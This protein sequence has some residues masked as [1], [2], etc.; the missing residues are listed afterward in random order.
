MTLRFPN[1][2]AF[3]LVVISGLIGVL[4]FAALMGVS[5][6]Q[7]RNQRID[8]A[9]IETENISLVLEAHALATVQKIDLILKDVQGH[10]RP[11][12]MCI[13]Q[14]DNFDGTA[15]HTLLKEKA[16]GIHKT[17]VIDMAGIYI[18]NVNGDCIHSSL[19]APSTFNIADR[20]YFQ[21]HRDNLA[22]GLLISAPQISRSFGTW[23][24]SFT[25][26]INFPNG[27]F[28]GVINVSVELSSFEKFYA[29]LNLGE[30]G[31]ILLRD[32]KMRLLARHP[33]LGA[34]IGEVMLNHPVLSFLE[35]GID[36][37]TYIAISP[38]DG[39]KRLYSFRRVGEYPLYVLA[40]I[41]EQDYLAD[42][43]RHL[44]WN[45][46]AAL[47]ILSAAL[48]LAMVARYG[49]LKWQTN[50][51]KYRYLVENAP[52]GVFQCD[53]HGK[54]IF[55]NLA[56]AKQFNCDSVESFQKTYNSPE[57]R[58]TTPAKL[59]A[60]KDAL[61]NQREISEFES[62][63]VLANG[64]TKWFSISAYLDEQTGQ[65]N[66]FTL[67]I[68]ERK[69]VEEQL[70]TSEERLRLTLEAAQIGVFDWDVKK[71]HFEVSPI[72][73]SMLGYPVKSGQGD[74]NEWLERLHPDDR[75]S[76]AEKIGAVLA[77]QE[78]AY[79]YEARMRHADGTYR[80]LAVKAFCV[81][82][83]EDGTVTRVL[84]IRVDITERKRSQE[85]LEHYKDHLERLV[86]E[87]T[88]ELETARKQADDANQ[89]KSDFLANMSHEIRTPMNAIIGLSQLALDTSL[90]EKQHD[91]LSKILNSSRALL[92]ILND[93]LDYSKIEAGR[94]E[95]EA[96]EFSLEEML[97]ATADLF[98][99]RADEKGLELF[100]DMAPDVPD[101]LLGD[102]LRLSQIIN[103]LVG[104][105]IKF[106]LQGEV[107]L[108]I[109][110]LERTND[111]I[112]LRFAVRDT[113]IGITT[114]QASR[115]FQPFVQ[116][117][118]S[119]TR[120]FG[121]T[122]LGLTICKRLVDMMGGEI[123]LSSGPDC[124]S[125]F[126]FTMRLGLPPKPSS[127]KFAKGRGLQN[128]RTMRTLVVDDQET[129][130]TIL[131]TILESWHF[132]VVTALS[133]AEG[134][135]LFAESENL[136][137]PFELLLLD[138]RMPNMSGLELAKTLAKEKHSCR[139]PVSIMVTAFGREELAKEANGVKLDA[140]IIKPVTPSNLFDT[141]IRLQ[142][143][144]IV[145]PIL[146][147]EAF[148]ASRETLKA[149]RGAHILLV[150]DNELNQQVAQEFL[151]KV[152]M[153]VTIA[154]N[155]QEALEW[156]N[157]A[158]FD[159]VLM[160]L[161]MPV[162]DGLEA[163]RRIRQLA[164]GHELPIIA[165]TAAAM[166]Q[167]REACAIAGMNDHIAKPV[168]LQELADTLVRWITPKF[169]SAVSEEPDE[170][171]LD[172]R[173]V[174]T[175]ESILPGLPVRAG[176]ARLGGNIP[177]YRRLLLAFVEQHRSLATV[178]HQLDPDHDRD[179]IFF[180]AHSLKGEAGN[181]G[182][183]TLKSL[184]NKLCQTV[185]SV[186]SAVLKG[187]M[188]VLIRECEAILVLLKPL[189][190]NM[191][192]ITPTSNVTSAAFDTDYLMS[193]L[194]ELA[195]QLKL[196]NL[197]ARYLVAELDGKITDPKLTVEFAEV[198]K[199]TQQL[200]YDIALIALEQILD[201]HG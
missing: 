139:P 74:R 145:Q 181:F 130:L 192:D 159:A 163:T 150:E 119:V 134:L 32:D 36:Q 122:G 114:D 38:A 47:V 195:V 96:V 98:S 41:A 85:E 65:V 10:I 68:T 97:R 59:A 7:E 187:D 197:D 174:A 117:D 151:I 166:T 46:I 137:K 5:L 168:E 161:H 199:A 99:I 120:K 138:W 190:E 198:A 83:D 186:D 179:Q 135:R 169:M 62:D 102:P 106:T 173:E 133:G 78:N 34:N 143:N 21:I 116:A 140:I 118:A 69:R 22:A 15:L 18:S 24:I 147:S 126:V 66:G 11:E 80:W 155:G 180:I 27:D 13:S 55:T 54:H 3:G 91:Y 152:G 77:K 17:A 52:L 182:F 67:D 100:I 165:M 50:E 31:A 201:H 136:G 160:D 131:R 183:E 33:A 144:E 64:V 153:D 39:I 6:F 63:C 45:V 176:L 23:K 86:N 26:R 196:K 44:I 58:F 8:H 9:R 170:L 177:L 110:A 178:F 53:V 172:D 4:G 87:R 200:R 141:L 162:M 72:Y 60:F 82:I 156:L 75:A 71:D 111:A 193:K 123:T 89:A 94:V 132:E 93:I 20:D 81:R 127:A 113:G 121:G 16:E 14:C 29:A 128:L 148:K 164:I 115:L 101:Q 43:S 171:V 191:A 105:A 49:I 56:L 167:D 92:G 129:S 185:K 188:E 42:W 194:R 70:R 149:I 57:L 146:V 95:I 184:A 25:R 189:V 142:R 112:Y 28:A 103:N 84:G 104:N 108:R 30:H 79:S 154:N 109:Q 88:A 51:R 90:D 40:A 1:I 76:V 125:T 157:K 175:L 37:G 12:D 2:S 19:D 73:Y 61:C 124:G 158:S 35:Q 48:V 107:H